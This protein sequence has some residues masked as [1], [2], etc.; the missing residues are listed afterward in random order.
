MYMQTALEAL[1]KSSKY[2]RSVRTDPEKQPFQE[3]MM[4][5]MNF[6]IM[7]KSMAM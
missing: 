6:Y 1:T 2:L 4:N 7:K 3:T 5:F